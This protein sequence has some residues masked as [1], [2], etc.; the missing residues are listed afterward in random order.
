MRHNFEKTMLFIE[1]G[2]HDTEYLKE[3]LGWLFQDADNAT[4]DVDSPKRKQLRDDMAVAMRKIR[5]LLG[6]SSK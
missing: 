3:V 6:E 1:A 5:S 4:K 2:F